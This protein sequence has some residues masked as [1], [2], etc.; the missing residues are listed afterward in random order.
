MRCVSY[1]RR[2][3]YW[4]DERSDYHKPNKYKK[5]DYDYYDLD[6]DLIAQQREHINAYADTLGWVVEEEYIDIDGLDAFERLKR[7]CISRKFDRVITDS[8]FRFSGDIGEARVTMQ[9][10]FIPV[11]IEVAIAQD[12]F[13][14]A[15]SSRKGTE[16]YFRSQQMRYMKEGDWIEGERSGE[17]PGSAPPKQ[18][19]RYSVP[20]RNN[21]PLG[22]RVHDGETGEALR[23]SGSLGTGVLYRNGDAGLIRWDVPCPTVSYSSIVEAVKETMRREKA[24][25]ELAEENIFSETAEKKKAALIAPLRERAE[26]LLGETDGLLARR[27]KRYNE[28]S[29]NSGSCDYIGSGDNTGCAEDSDEARRDAERLARI[30]EEFNELMEKVKQI[31]EA[32]SLSNRWMKTYA[33]ID[34]PANLKNRHIRNY[35]S[36]IRVYG[37]GKGEG[38]SAQVIVRNDEYRSILPQEWFK[39]L[40]FNLSDPIALDEP[41]VSDCSD[42]NET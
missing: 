37:F 36:D 34:I 19:A 2:D 9:H 6:G 32:Y 29:D 21:T 30:D 33:G 15:L 18:Y 20:N 22:S 40:T 31:D 10:I 13:C 3:S 38:Y 5:G 42:G 35:I 16:Y 1:M 4:R 26:Q 17:D 25:A 27:M 41:A 8:F 28:S 7:D 24:A 11:G 14:S 23:F 12:K 39:S